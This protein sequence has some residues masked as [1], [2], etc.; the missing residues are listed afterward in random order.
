MTQTCGHVGPS[1]PIGEHTRLVNIQM[2]F[3][4]G[5]VESDGIARS[6]LMILLLVTLGER[7]END[8]SRSPSRPNSQIAFQ[9]VSAI[10]GVIMRRVNLHGRTLE[11]SHLLTPC[12]M[13]RAGRQQSKNK[14][15]VG[16]E[17]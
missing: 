10:H 16:E 3:I 11:L 8:S 7:H 1:M 4:S 17:L 6:V 9:D 15:H 13:D 14:P 5:W 12:L 2:S